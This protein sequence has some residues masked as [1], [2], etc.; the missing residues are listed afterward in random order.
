MQDAVR[1]LAR[2][3][4][5]QIEVR[6]IQEKRVQ[7]QSDYSQELYIER[8]RQASTTGGRSGQNRLAQCIPYCFA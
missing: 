3:D 4:G 6:F 7:T 2:T 1:E 5:T 8:S